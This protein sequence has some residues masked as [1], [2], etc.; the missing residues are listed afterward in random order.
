LPLAASVCVAAVA[1]AASA[2]PAP[3]QE[4][5]KV[6]ACTA[7]EALSAS[8]QRAEASSS[9]RES[10]KT[11]EGRRQSCFFRGGKVFFV[12]VLK[13]CFCGVSRDLSPPFLRFSFFPP[14]LPL[15][16]PS[17]TCGAG[18]T[19][20]SGLPMS[21]LLRSIVTCATC[22]AR[23]AAEEEDEA[24][25]FLFCGGGGGGGGVRRGKRGS[26][27]EEGGGRRRKRGGETDDNRV[28]LLLSSFAGET[29]ALTS[30]ARF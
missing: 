22:A 21:R 11:L 10:S 26:R 27:W 24:S 15:L 29:R 1:V 9:G 17:L 23:A 25:Y 30:I 7:T 12:F 28:L 2:V 19:R 14:L 3:K 8:L 4:Y 18:A 13:I 20:E 5:S 6:S 16:F